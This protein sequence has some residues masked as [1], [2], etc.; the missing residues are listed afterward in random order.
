MSFLMRLRAWIGMVAAMAVFWHGVLLARHS[1]AMADALR[2]HRAFL[3][4]MMSLCR[5]RSGETSDAATDLPPLPSVPRP[6]DGAGCLVC[7]GLVDAVLPTQR[8]ETLP[9][10]ATPA[11]GSAEAEQR[12]SPLQIAHPLA[13]GPPLA[14]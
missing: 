13:R 7:A 1:V 5:T 3:A 10:P 12:V 9:A 14:A 8:S 2:H 6:D 4:D 11:V